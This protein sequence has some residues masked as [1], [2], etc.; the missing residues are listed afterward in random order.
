M[1]TIYLILQIY[2]SISISGSKFLKRLQN[3]KFVFILCEFTLVHFFLFII[4]YHIL[5]ILMRVFRCLVVENYLYLWTDLLPRCYRTT[6]FR[7]KFAPGQVD[8][9]SIFSPC[10]LRG[11]RSSSSPFRLVAILLWTFLV[12]WVQLQK[13]I[14]PRL[15]GISGLNHL[16]FSIAEVF[17][18]D[19]CCVM[20]EG[21]HL[22][23]PGKVNGRSCPGS[24]LYLNDVCIIVIKRVLLFKLFDDVSHN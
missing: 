1:R 11:I 22:L 17:E 2:T 5:I 21:L 8:N 12:L 3:I 14:S 19:M 16:A 18:I 9:I 4:M 10:R 24:R 13:G 15:F 23:L 6:D 7:A 20:H